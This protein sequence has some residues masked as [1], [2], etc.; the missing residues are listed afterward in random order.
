MEDLSFCCREELAK[1][2]APK[3]V[4]N[5][6][7]LADKLGFSDTEI[8]NFEMF[9]GNECVTGMLYAFNGRKNASIP[10]LYDALVAIGRHDACKVI[11]KHQKGMTF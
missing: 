11:R 8:R 9:K 4:T 1:L 3:S 6:R 2:L 7:H 10:T 5:W